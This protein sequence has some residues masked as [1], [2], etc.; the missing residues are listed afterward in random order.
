MRLPHW[1]V[2]S[3]LTMSLLAVLGAGAWWLVTWSGPIK[4]RHTSFAD[5][6]GRIPPG[7]GL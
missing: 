5:K 6:L 1:L 3:L 7:S 4:R 2:V